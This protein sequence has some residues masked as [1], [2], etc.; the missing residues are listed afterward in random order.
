[1]DRLLRAAIPAALL[2]IA[3]PSLVATTP[4]SAPDWRVEGPPLGVVRR[5]LSFA[6]AT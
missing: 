3:A 6:A 1:M 2:S 5:H 4:Q